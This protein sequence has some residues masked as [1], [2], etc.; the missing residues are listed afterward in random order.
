[1]SCLQVGVW[2]ASM[3]AEYGEAVRATMLPPPAPPPPPPPLATEPSMAHNSFTSALPILSKTAGP[4]QPLQS[5]GTPNPGTPGT[6]LPTRVLLAG[7]GENP[8]GP[9]NASSPSPPPEEPAS[10][11]LKGFSVDYTQVG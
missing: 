10:R 11:F 1:M 4:M 3:E 8:S 9:R 6:P 2:D 5:P 7:G